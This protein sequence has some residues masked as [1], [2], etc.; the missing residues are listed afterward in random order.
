MHSTGIKLGKLWGIQELFQKLKILLVRDHHCC[1]FH[2][3]QCV[4]GLCGIY[5]YS[6][7]I[8]KC[9]NGFFHFGDEVLALLAST[10]GS[11][12]ADRSSKNSSIN[13]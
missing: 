8:E 1:S 11:I 3:L 6:E 9:Q 5:Q 2:T 10:Q 4:I 12:K 13:R 7:E